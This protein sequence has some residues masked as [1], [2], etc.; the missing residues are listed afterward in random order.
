MRIWM[1]SFGLLVFCDIVVEGDIDSRLYDAF[2]FLTLTYVNSLRIS[3]R[4][5]QCMH[6][7][8]ASYGLFL[9]IFCESKSRT[10]S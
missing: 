7:L 9:N 2:V 10:Y 1:L 4:N 8:L 3:L 6:M 5:R